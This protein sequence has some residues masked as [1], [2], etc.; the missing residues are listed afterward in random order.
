MKTML[1]DC[2]SLTIVIHVDTFELLLVVVV[3]GLMTLS[4]VLVPFM[5]GLLLLLMLVVT[6]TVSQ[7]QHIEVIMTHIILMTHCGME[8]DV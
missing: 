4:I 6:I 3:K 1:L 2:Q 5:E 7:D 8:Q